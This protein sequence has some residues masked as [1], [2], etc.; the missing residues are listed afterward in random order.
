MPW[1]RTAPLNEKIARKM[2][3]SFRFYLRHNLPGHHDDLDRCQRNDGYDSGPTGSEA[4]PPNGRRAG[5]ALI[6]HPDKLGGHQG[7]DNQR[8]HKKSY[9]HAC[10][11]NNAVMYQRVRTKTVDSVALKTCFVDQSTSQPLLD[12]ITLEGRKIACFV[13][14]QKIQLPTLAAKEKTFSGLDTPHTLTFS[15][16]EPWSAAKPRRE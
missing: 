4:L 6:H 1:A 7:D 5:I 15:L 9:R 8:H 16:P 10:V 13:F 11:V 2:P 12:R 3:H 14:C